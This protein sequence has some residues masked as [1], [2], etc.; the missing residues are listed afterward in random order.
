[1][2][3]IKIA[4]LEEIALSKKWITKKKILNNLKFYGNNEYSNYLKNL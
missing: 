2:Q 1:V 4:C 3:G